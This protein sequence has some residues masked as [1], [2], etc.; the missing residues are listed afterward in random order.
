MLKIKN[1]L[2]LAIIPFSILDVHLVYGS[3]EQQP[4]SVKDRVREIDRAIAKHQSKQDPKSAEEKV[5]R[6]K[7]D[8][9][10][11]R[12]NEELK[13]LGYQNE[14]SC[15]LQGKMNLVFRDKNGKAITGRKAE[16]LY[17]KAKA[18]NLNQ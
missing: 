8:K 9:K 17:E 16:E 5:K 11:Q 4:I 18:G 13:I 10:Q 3:N 7:E 1:L 15:D 6:E 2:F 12:I 14:S